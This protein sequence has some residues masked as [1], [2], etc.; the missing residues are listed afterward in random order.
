ML[1]VSVDEDWALVVSDV[2]FLAP[3][4]EVEVASALVVDAVWEESLAVVDVGS[5]S[6][7]PTPRTPSRASPR[8]P[9][10]PAILD[11]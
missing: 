7:P 10:G 1:G 9:R 11:D 6:P 3:A 4:D 2:P 8:S 5:S